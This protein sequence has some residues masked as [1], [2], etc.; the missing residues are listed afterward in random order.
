MKNQ[1]KAL[2]IEIRKEEGMSIGDISKKLGVAKSSVSLW[3]RDIVLTQEQREVL[4]N[5]NP[6]FNKS[7]DGAKAM[8]KKARKIRAQYQKEGRDLVHS[9]DRSKKE[10]LIAGS[11]LFWAEGSKSKNSITFSNSDPYMMLFFV[12]FLKEVFNITE[13]KMSL[14]L[15][16]YTDFYSLEEIEKYWL[17]LLSFSKSNCRKHTVNYYSSYSKK[18]RKGKLKYGTCR[19]QIGNTRIV[20]QIYGAIQE[21]ASFR[22]DGQWLK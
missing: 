19:I 5:K 2:A 10:L 11:M 21:I 14:Y 6:A 3:V 1:E 4:N 17:N 18:K 15:N 13:D 9:L 16:C 22:E 7:Y 12:K 8:M 20:Q